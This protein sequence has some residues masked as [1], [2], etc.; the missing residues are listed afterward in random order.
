VR[1]I[2]EDTGT[3]KDDI[4][5]HLKKKFLTPRRYEIGGEVGARYTTTTLKTD[6]MAEYMDKIYAWA[7]ST[8][9]IILPLPEEYMRDVA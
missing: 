2:H 6:E 1:L 9:G 3:D 7:T 5:D 8:F 4:H